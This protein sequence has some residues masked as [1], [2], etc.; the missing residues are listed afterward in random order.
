MALIDLIDANKKFNTKIILENANFSA[1]L[2]EKI[3]IIG[4]NGEGKSSFLKALMGTLKLDSGKVIKQNNASIGMLS[5]Q[6]S[7]QSSLSVNE[8]I[9][10][11]LEE[12]YQALQEYENY[13]EKLAINPENKEYLKKVDELSLFIDSKDAWNLD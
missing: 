13:N 5:Q 2:G 9:K 8:A 7:F 10:Q 1:N 12:I 6:V 11:E 4:K 3:A